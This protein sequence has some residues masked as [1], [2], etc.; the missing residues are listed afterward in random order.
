MGAKPHY[1]LSKHEPYPSRA[2]DKCSE[3]ISS[4]QGGKMYWNP[5]PRA[6]YI[7]ICS[8][9]FDLWASK[10]REKV[11]RWKMRRAALRALE[12]ETKTAGIS[13]ERASSGMNANEGASMTTSE[14]LSRLRAEGFEN[15]KSHIIGHGIKAGAIPRP[16]LSAS[17]AFTW[18][19]ENLSAARRYLRNVP[20]PGRKSDALPADLPPTTA[21]LNTELAAYKQFAADIDAAFA[22]PSPRGLQLD[23]QHAYDQLRASIKESME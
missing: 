19:D 16:E 13:S 17:L 9:C 22:K 1:I 23:Y 14:V 2:C 4:V 21:D 5:N 18:S 3:I 12:L 10:K 15:A 11:K 7:N 8:N 6:V 20:K